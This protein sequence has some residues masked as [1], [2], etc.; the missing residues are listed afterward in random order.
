MNKK[1]RCSFKLST[2]WNYR[3]VINSKFWLNVKRLQ[4]RWNI[5]VSKNVQNLNS[6]FYAKNCITAK[7]LIK[8]HYEHSS[9]IIYNTHCQKQ[10]MHFK[11]IVSKYHSKNESKNTNIKNK[12][13]KSKRV[14]YYIDSNTHAYI[15]D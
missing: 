2:I 10:N 6:N 11:W 8:K 13:L 1:Y 15:F 4:K 14:F 5:K 9:K 12:L 3:S 7:K